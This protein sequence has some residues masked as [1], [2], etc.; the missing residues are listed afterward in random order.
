M[1]NIINQSLCKSCGMCTELCPNKVIG[2]DDRIDF[3]EEREHL[4]QQCGQC[5]AV[6]PVKAVHVEGLSYED[7]FHEFAGNKINYENFLE[8]LS[9]RRSVRAFKDRPVSEELI[10]EVVDSVSYAPFGAAPEKM[11]ISVINNRKTIESAL[12]LI[13]DFL[14]GIGRM[15]ENP[16]ASGALKFIAGKEDF[17]TKKITYTQSLR[18]ESMILTIGME[19]P[20]AHLQS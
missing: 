9:S 16:I 15:I 2:R 18:V 12:P 11:E 14:N 4:C 10:D 3:I 13:S 17:R 6:C 1:K 7:D 20:E 19:S 8:I 5:M